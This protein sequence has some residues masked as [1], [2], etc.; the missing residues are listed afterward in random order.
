MIG[1]SHRRRMGGGWDSDGMLIG[2]W[3]KHIVYWRSSIGPLLGDLRPRAL[4][5]HLAP[6]A[7][8]QHLLVVPALVDL[9]TGPAALLLG[10]WVEAG[11]DGVGSAVV[12]PA[13]DQLAALQLLH[14]LRALLLTPALL[15][16]FA[17]PPVLHALPTVQQAGTIGGFGV[18]VAGVIGEDVEVGGWGDFGLSAGPVRLLG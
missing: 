3:N 16:Q 13:H 1:N 11:S 17:H 14:H 5:A 9:Q 15:G 7:E 18:G 2:K 10:S 8:P 6:S 4:E 12:Q